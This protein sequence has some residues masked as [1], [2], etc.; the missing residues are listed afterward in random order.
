M[1]SHD[2]EFKSRVVEF[3]KSHTIKETMEKFC[4]SVMTV[5]NW[6]KQAGYD[7]KK[8]GAPVRSIPTHWIRFSDKNG[9]KLKGRDCVRL[10][11]PSIEK[12]EPMVYDGIIGYENC[13]FMI[14]IPGVPS[15]VYL[16]KNMRYY[17]N[18]T[19]Y[20]GSITPEMIEKI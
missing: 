7:G 4:L 9:V 10:T 17:F 6:A 13:A 1:K 5:Y 2:D 20:F 16:N 14:E 3:R 12:K 8:P 18:C 15:K 19:Y 11:L